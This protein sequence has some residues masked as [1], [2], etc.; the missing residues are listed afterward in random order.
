MSDLEKFNLGKAQFEKLFV[1]KIQ[2]IDKN[3]NNIATSI[4]EVF[5]DAYKNDD[6]Q[7]I[8]SSDFGK[9]IAR[10]ATDPEHFMYTKECDALFAFVNLC[11]E[12]SSQG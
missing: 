8:G 6:F 10:I 5:G 12:L 11:D 2:E 4:M 7:E 1:G 3:H 9:A